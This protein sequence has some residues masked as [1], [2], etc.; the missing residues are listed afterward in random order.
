MENFNFFTDRPPLTPD[1]VQAHKNFDKVLQQYKA[2]PPV[3]YYKSGWFKAGLATVTVVATGTILFFATGQNNNNHSEQKAATVTQAPY[4]DESPCVKSPVPQL[5]VTEKQFVINPNRDT[6]LYYETGSAIQVKAHSLTDENGKLIEDQVTIRYREFHNPVE[7]FASGIPMQYDSAGQ[8]WNLQSAGM[9]EISAWQGDKKLLIKPESPLTVQMKSGVPDGNFNVYYLDTVQRNWAYKNR[10][11]V[12][13]AQKTQ[14]NKYQH[15]NLK[16]IVRKIDT[17]KIKQELAVMLPVM[18]PR[19]LNPKAFSFTLDVLES[20]FPE[21]AVYKTTKFEVEDKNN[22]FDS[23]IYSM[24]WEDA[25]LKT[26]VA[27][28][29]YELTLTRGH[30]VK[31]FN[32]IPV[33]EGKVY[34]AA[35]GEYKKKYK[36]Y[37]DKLAARLKEEKIRVEREKAELSKWEREQ[38]EKHRLRIQ[39]F[40][41]ANMPNDQVLAR[42]GADNSNKALV[43]RAFI[44]SKFGIWN[45]DRPADFPPGDK[46]AARFFDQ[47][48]EEI[49]L[50]V[51]YLCDKKSKQV[52]TYNPDQFH[53]FT[54]DP[55]GNNVVWGIRADG[56]I[57]YGLNNVFSAENRRGKEMHF[58]LNIIHDRLTTLKQVKDLLEI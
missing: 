42:F 36:E 31:T 47:S 4:A 1:E 14:D 7:I 34:T 9:M 13:T 26:I 21:L 33:L 6:I 49:P 19:A 51:A 44:V 37:E 12:L 35:L 58:G 29:K 55:K 43:T 8:T 2:A 25:S 27:G 23:K 50:Q 38:E 15:S 32:V 53:R 5:D 18:K 41:S 11:E 40:T 3:K 30:I 46:V 54:F 48:G 20:E 56:K 24:D 45:C 52:Y 16:P 39:D 17:V 57:A 10:D 28:E 22:V